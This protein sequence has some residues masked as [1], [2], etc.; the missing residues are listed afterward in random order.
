[1]TRPDLKQLQQERKENL[2]KLNLQQKYQQKTMEEVDKDFLI[3]KLELILT[4]K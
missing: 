1:M 3:D 4:F 2:K